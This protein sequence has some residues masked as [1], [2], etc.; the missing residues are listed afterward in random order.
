VFQEIKH[1][2]LRKIEDRPYNARF[3]PLNNNLMINK[4][5]KNK[6]LNFGLSYIWDGNETVE[7]LDIKFL[8]P[9]EEKVKLQVYNLI[10]S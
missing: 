7:D 10:T 2:M 9:V 8:L 4:V 3:K 6:L 5:I 1:T